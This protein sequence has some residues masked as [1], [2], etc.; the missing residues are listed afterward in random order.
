MTRIGFVGVGAISG[1]YLEGGQS[2]TYDLSQST[3]ISGT[4]DTGYTVANGNGKAEIGS[5]IIIS[6]GFCYDCHKISLG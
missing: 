2:R 4:G 3:C 1:I 6:D 5:T